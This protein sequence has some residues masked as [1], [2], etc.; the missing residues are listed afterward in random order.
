MT[1]AAKARLGV[2]I[3]RYFVTLLHRGHVEEVAPESLRREIGVDRRC[4][5]FG[6]FPAQSGPMEEQVLQL[7]CKLL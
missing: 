6:H 2:A 3:K 5:D 7:A 4:H 1:A